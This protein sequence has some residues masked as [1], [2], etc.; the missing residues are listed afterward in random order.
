M[1]PPHPAPYTHLQDSQ[2]TLLLEQ[3]SASSSLRLFVLV[4]S[5]FA[6]L[7]ADTGRARTAR[8][9]SPATASNNVG[10]TKRLLNGRRF[11]LLGVPGYTERGNLSNGVRSP[12]ASGF[13]LPSVVNVGVPHSSPCWLERDSVNSRARPRP[14]RTAA[15]LQNFAYEYSS[16]PPYPTSAASTHRFAST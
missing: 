4:L 3:R 9:V 6:G 15:A 8:Q 11:V 10:L 13:S 5:L 16:Q 7:P 1:A 12:I 2:P 14:R